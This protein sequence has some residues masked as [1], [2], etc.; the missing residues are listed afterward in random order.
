MSR[1]QS[2]EPIDQK[3]ADRFMEYELWASYELRFIVAY[4]AA[5]RFGAGVSAE[6]SHVVFVPRSVFNYVCRQLVKGRRKEKWLRIRNHK[7]LTPHDTIRWL[8]GKQRYTHIV[9]W[10]QMQLD[11]ADRDKILAE[12]RNGY[13]DNFTENPQG[14][15][16][17]DTDGTSPG[18]KW[19]S[20][21]EELYKNVEKVYL[22]AIL[23]AKKIGNTTGDDTATGNG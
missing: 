4:Q 21:T 2:F 5:Q 22:Q 19:P 17:G 23:E 7:L 18:Y 12:Y 20:S 14:G 10:D 8:L 6:D 15:W 9:K 1:S 11:A 16:W 13:F 3:T